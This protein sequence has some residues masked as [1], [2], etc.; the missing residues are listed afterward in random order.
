[1]K[2]AK[3]QKK[4]KEAVENWMDIYMQILTDGLMDGEIDRDGE[5]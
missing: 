3:R 5:D 4:I 2:M 1:M